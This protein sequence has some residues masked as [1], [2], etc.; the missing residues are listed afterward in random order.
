MSDSEAERERLRQL[1]RAQRLGVLSSH[2][3]GQPHASL[4]AFAA[5][6]D[7]RRL[8]FATTRATRKYANLRADARVA[9]I[10]D[11]RSN[12]DADFH[13][14]MAVTAYGRALELSGAERDEYLEL[15]LGKHPH[16]CEFVSAPTCALVAIA[17]QRYSMVDRF[18]HVVELA[19]AV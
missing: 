17:V 5:T 1:L 18:Q 10:V 7:L 2:D 4:V 14:A 11:N 8:V 3:N 9:L 19:V 6:D 16:L 13:E 15:Y 12:R